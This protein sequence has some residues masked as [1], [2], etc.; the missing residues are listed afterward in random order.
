MKLMQIQWFGVAL[1]ATSLPVGTVFG[2]RSAAAQVPAAT[3]PLPA[4]T[5]PP[6][7]TAVSAVPANP[8]AAV[9]APPQATPATAAAG[10]LVPSPASVT[11]QAREQEIERR[12]D[13]FLAEIGMVGS[14]NSPVASGD[15]SIATRVLARKLGPLLGQS[16]TTASSIATTTALFPLGIPP[17]PVG[18]AT[19][20]SEMASLSALTQ[21]V[22]LKLAMEQFR[23]TARL[24]QDS[25][26]GKDELVT[27]RNKVL[28]A[29]AA[30]ES[31]QEQLQDELDRI[32]LQ[33]KK[34]KVEVE[35]S[36]L[37]RNLASAPVARNKRLSVRDTGTV[38]EDESKRD[39]T[40]LLI[41]D[42]DQ[43]IKSLEVEEL[44][45]RSGKLHKRLDRIAHAAKLAAKFEHE[46]Q[47]T[48][49][50]QTK[51]PK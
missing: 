16:S 51:T 4:V 23:I 2:V 20:G 8:T 35:R 36:Q 13:L 48:L 15:T 21:G 10:A 28:L 18:E 37:L 17:K 46:T 24:S 41:A 25:V 33:I 6:A 19:S 5:S 47:Q 12:L 49:D 30:L 27:A 34:M 14:S 39:E 50:K 9:A 45:H 11:N 42:A 38:S 31:N 43:K 29:K 26:I 40:E 44:E 3:S 1:L 7:Q 32:E 22:D